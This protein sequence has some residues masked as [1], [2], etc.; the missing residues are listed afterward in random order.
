MTSVNFLSSL[1][2]RAATPSS[3]SPLYIHERP[4]RTLTEAAKADEDGNGVLALRLYERGVEALLETIK[5]EP[6]AAVQQQMRQNAGRCL[7]RAEELK[8]NAPARAPPVRQPPPPPV[9]PPAANRSTARGNGRGAGR[10]GP[11]PIAPRAGTAV[12]AARGRI[13][14]AAGG[15][16]AAS[17]PAPPPPPPLDAGLE[18]AI[19]TENPGVSWDDVAGLEDA[20]AA[21]HEAVVLP[22]KFPSLF[23]GAR[24]PWKGVLLY[25][26]PGTGQDIYTYTH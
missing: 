12:G 21:L 22:V 14:A 19:M 18:G 5:N 15:A 11:A 3:N 10:R 23:V 7:E 6:D 17:P 24:K 8:R 1:L 16:A 26:P 25:G 2:R 4:L 20:K 13:G 9:A